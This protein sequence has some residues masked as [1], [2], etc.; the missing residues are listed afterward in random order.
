MCVC[1]M[2]GIILLLRRVH[3]VCNGVGINLFTG[4]VYRVLG[5]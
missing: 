2:V 1:N 5:D 4:R 3:I